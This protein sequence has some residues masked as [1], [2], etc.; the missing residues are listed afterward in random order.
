MNL[1]KEATN[2]AER[3][4]K[5]YH[6]SKINPDKFRCDLLLMHIISDEDIFIESHSF[7][8]DLC[9]MLVLDEY[10]KTIVY[11]SNQSQE[12]RNFTIGHELGHY[13][14]HR[15]KKSQFADRTKDMLNNSI[16]TFEMQANAFAS[17][18]LL[19]NLIVH[20]MISNGYHFYQIK[21]QAQVSDQA[22]F[23][24]LVNYLCNIHEIAKDQAKVIVNEFK[25]FS[26]ASMKNLIH[27]KFSKIYEIILGDTHH[28]YFNLTP[29]T[30]F[31][32][33]RDS[34]NEIIGIRDKNII[35]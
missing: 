8:T 29:E 3:I 7:S 11:N 26:I 2:T 34:L 19:P 12:R 31:E 22:L 16:S 25:D 5:Q 21:R 18:L 14:L 24:R 4:Y 9:G 13:Y 28:R 35:T 23:W 30:N 20:K 32:F 15:D 10:E 27:H 1:I 6:Y 17:Q 33:V